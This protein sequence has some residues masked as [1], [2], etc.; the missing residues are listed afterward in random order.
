MGRSLD[1]LVVHRVPR[2]TSDIDPNKVC[3]HHIKPQ[4]SSIGLVGG[5]GQIEM[6]HLANALDAAI[7]LSVRTR[8]HTSTFKETGDLRR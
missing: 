8:L 1:V 7:D 2:G 6:F 4:E 3:A 5:N